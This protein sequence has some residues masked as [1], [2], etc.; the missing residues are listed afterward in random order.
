[1]L[2]GRNSRF[3]FP[4][5]Q[6]F[7]LMQIIFIVLP[8]NMAAVQNLYK[9]QLRGKGLNAMSCM[10]FFVSVTKC[11]PHPRPSL[12]IQHHMNWDMKMIEVVTSS[13]LSSSRSQIH[14]HVLYN[15]RMKLKR[16]CISRTRCKTVSPPARRKLTQIQLQTQLMW[17]TTPIK[18]WPN[19][20]CFV[21]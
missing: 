5:E 11:P 1:M 10:V 18:H 14:V 17:L 19:H 7:F 13:K 8:S 21:T 16:L 2:H 9:C 15:W 20:V 4:C 6:M 12:Q 3:F